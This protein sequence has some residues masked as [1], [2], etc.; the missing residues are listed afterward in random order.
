MLPRQSADEYGALKWAVGRNEYTEK[1]LVN[2]Y[3]IKSEHVLNLN[4]QFYFSAQIQNSSQTEV[5][6]VR[7]FY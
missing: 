5:S 2:K 1:Y 6:G 3:S 7:R 4:I